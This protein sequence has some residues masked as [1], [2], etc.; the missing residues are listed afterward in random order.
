MANFSVFLVESCCKSTAAPSF[1]LASTTGK[2]TARKKSV[3][4]QQ[5]AISLNPAAADNMDADV[6]CGFTWRANVNRCGVGEH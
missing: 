1:L 6:H 4:L 2:F 5:N 3:N